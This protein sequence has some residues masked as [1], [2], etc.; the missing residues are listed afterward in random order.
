MLNTWIKENA[1]NLIVTG[2][3][4][5]MAWSLLSSRVSA[6]EL[7]VTELS[8]KVDTLQILVERVIV[9]EERENNIEADILEIKTDI[10]EIKR[11]L[12]GY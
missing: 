4:L 8:A 1:W 12:N 6:N 9:L 11:S 3:A 10:K 5:V 2:V 7:H